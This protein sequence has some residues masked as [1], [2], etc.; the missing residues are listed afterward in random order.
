MPKLTADELSAL[1]L[2]LANVCMTRKTDINTIATLLEQGAEINNRDYREQTPLALAVK[3]GLDIVV[4]CL[5]KNGADIYSRHEY[6]RTVLM[7]IVGDKGERYLN[8][9][10]M[11]ISHAKTTGIEISHFLN[12]VD[13]QHDTALIYAIK[14]NN[15]TACAL[16][17]EAGAS[18]D[19]GDKHGNSPLMLAN[20]N[21]GINDVTKRYRC[22]R[23]HH[24]NAYQAAAQGWCKPS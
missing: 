6:E 11:I 3:S 10:N 2:E 8:I 13:T 18:C 22:R 5:I 19:L 9:L 14:V 20:S 23:S 7:T 1:N 12:A 17:L 15:I 16:L 21:N 24:P 4:D